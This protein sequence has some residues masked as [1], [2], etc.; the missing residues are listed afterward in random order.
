MNGKNIN[1]IDL[2]KENTSFEKVI[3]LLN[4]GIQKDTQYVILCNYNNS[5]SFKDYLTYVD[6]C[7]SVI[8]DKR[9]QLAQQKYNLNFDDLPTAQ[10]QEI[11]KTYPIRLSEQNIDEP[12]D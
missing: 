10:Q 11:Q 3:N 5:T 2:T 6:M 9:N 7:Y 8:L 1:T 12:E 4:A